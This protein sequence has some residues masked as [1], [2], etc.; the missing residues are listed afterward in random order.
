MTDGVGTDQF[1]TVAV[2]VSG[3][4]GLLLGSFF[5]VVAYR[6][7]RGMSVMSPRRSICPSCDAPIAARD[8]VPV[9][10]WLILRGRCRSCGEPISPVY[11]AVELATGGL[12][13]AIVAHR[14]VDVSAIPD[15]VLAST[16]VIVT[17]TDLSHHT[18]PNRVTLPA[19][20]IAVPAQLAAR[21]DEWAQW[22]GAGAGAF[23]F[24]LIA[25]LA[26][27]AGM[28]MGD[29]KLA[30]VMGLYLGTA[31]I[32]ALLIGF[33]LGTVVGIGVMIKLGIE[34]GRKA[35]VPFAPFMAAGGAIALFAGDPIVEWYA[36]RFLGGA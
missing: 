24:M 28:G 11:P 20:I 4:A 23:T 33:L 5:N 26:Y 35:G 21:P 8:N 17:A 19:V 12:F 6:L 3:I 9:I 27:P 15:L 36:D 7:P 31:V 29:V 30:G 32:P 18:I 25:A 10:S 16:L 22:L 2:V 34:R 1:V 14:G 13:A